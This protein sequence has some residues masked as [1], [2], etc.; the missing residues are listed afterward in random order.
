MPPRDM[1]STT[2]VLKHHIESLGYRVCVACDDPVW[3]CSAK[4]DEA[5]QF[6]VV[7]SDTEDRAIAEICEL[8]GINLEDG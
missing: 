5:G 3:I 4:N 7:K 8:I 2:R 6:F 1:K